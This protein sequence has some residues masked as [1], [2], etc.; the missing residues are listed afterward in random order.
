[1]MIKW[2]GDQR[3]VPKVGLCTKG[4]TKEVPEDTGKGLIKQGLAVT[5]KQTTK[6]GE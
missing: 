3:E 6:K 2:V 1:M 5:Y 4:D